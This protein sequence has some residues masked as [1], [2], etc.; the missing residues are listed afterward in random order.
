MNS[1]RRFYDYLYDEGRLKIEN[2][3]KKGM[4]V[5]LPRPLPKYLKDEQVDELLEHVHMVRDRALF[6]L[7][8][9]TGVRV[10]EAA[11]LTFDDIDFH[12]GRILIRAGKGNMDQIVYMSPGAVRLIVEYLKA[13]PSSRSKHVFLVDKGTHRGQPLSVRGIQKRMEYYARKA[14]LKTSCHHLRHTMATQMLNAGAALATIQDLLGHASVTTTQKYCKT[15]NRRV[16]QDYYQTIEKV[17]E[18]TAPIEDNES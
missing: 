9:R 18:R 12:R 1:I 2:P 8:L 15:S 5:R 17:I 14:S 3:V 11:N 4:C 7:M 13:R 6:T 16:Q 10:A